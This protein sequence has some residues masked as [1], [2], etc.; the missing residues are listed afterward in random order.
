MS[1][2]HHGL[3]DGRAIVIGAGV[4]GLVAA[5]YLA[6]AGRRVLVLERQD[7]IDGRADA[8]WVPPQ[9]ID[10]LR[11]DRHGLEIHEPDPWIAAALPDGGGDAWSCRAT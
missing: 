1:H 6:R 4:N 2:E 8:G 9:V 3:A 5:H 10:E 7:E 11:L